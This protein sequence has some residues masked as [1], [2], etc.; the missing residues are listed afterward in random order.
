MKGVPFLAVAEEEFLVAA[1]NY[2]AISGTLGF[3]FIEEVERAVARI[4]TF[5]EHGSPHYGGTRRVVLRRFPYDIV[6]REFGSELRIVAV[7]PQRS[8]PFYWRSR[9]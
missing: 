6:Y 4:A 7:A 8:E 2:A 9:T 3:A 1:Q 5:P